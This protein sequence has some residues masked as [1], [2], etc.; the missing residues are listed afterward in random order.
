MGKIDWQKSAA[1]IFCI[2]AGG[3]A[4]WFIIHY[5]L[6]ILLPFIVAWAVALAVAPA[7]G[8][9]SKKTGIPIK[10]C[11][12]VLLAAV[13]GILISLVA[14]LLDR[15]IYEMGRLADWLVSGESD[16][17]AT[18]G[19]LAGGIGSLG[20]KIPILRDM[21]G[22]EEFEDF[23]AGVNDMLAKLLTDFIS[24]LSM[25]VPEAV[26]RMISR[27]P[28]VLLLLT[29][30]LIACFYFCIDLRSVNAAL[31][32]IMPKRVAQQMPMLKSRVFSA[33]GKWVKAYLI[34]FCI[35]FAEL[36]AGFIILGV[37]YPLLIALVGALVDILPVFGTGT[38][39]IPWG[40]FSLFT[41]DFKL[42]FGLIILYAATLIIRQIAEP[43][44]VG[45]SF[46]IHP[47]LALAAMYSGFRLFGIAGMILFPAAVMLLK[48]IFVTEEKTKV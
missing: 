16:L 37:E 23:F 25:W 19:R 18:L 46:G 3:F 9:I 12:A 8:W 47:L 40:L 28:S 1:V 42:G 13:L 6:G 32:S 4:L 5:L 22:I 20:E 35:T 26:F 14:L 48:N 45:G 10:L 2:A 21:K 34:L 41:K 39:L 43:R 33:A 29:V 27:L 44:V 7:A 11:S 30:T 31:L 36:F 17:L 38:I 24:K 15:L